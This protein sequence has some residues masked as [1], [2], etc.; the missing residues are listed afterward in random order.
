MN[1]S[2]R[3]GGEMELRMIVHHRRES[4][5]LPALIKYRRKE[6][7]KWQHDWTNVIMQPPAPANVL[8]WRHGESLAFRTLRQLFRAGVGCKL[9]GRSSCIVPGRS[10]CVSS[11]A[12]E[13][14]LRDSVDKSALRDV[15]GVG[16][17]RE[18][19]SSLSPASFFVTWCVYHGS[20]WVPSLLVLQCC[21]T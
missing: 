6:T 21:R 10:A 1:L 13:Q 8:L 15:S 12:A 20:S 2:S 7:K 5:E 18:T 11:S 9:D 14:S 16:Q 4:H 17:P 19:D 3:R